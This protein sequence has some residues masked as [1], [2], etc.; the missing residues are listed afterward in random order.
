MKYKLNFVLLILVLS[1]CS[2]R[3][4]ANLSKT[5][6]QQTVEQLDSSDKS[7]ESEKK[8]ALPAEVNMKESGKQI[9]PSTLQKIIDVSRTYESPNEVSSRCFIDMEYLFLVQEEVNHFD[10]G[11]TPWYEYAL[12]GGSYDTYEKGLNC[13]N[14]VNQLY[15]KKQV[16]RD[17]EE[18][19]ERCG[20]GFLAQYYQRHITAFSP[21]G[22][23]VLLKTFI[24]PPYQNEILYEIYNN[25]K[26]QHSYIYSD[27]TFTDRINY[28][29]GIEFVS[30]DV[31]HGSLAPCGEIYPFYWMGKDVGFEYLNLKDEEQFE[32]SITTDSDDSIYYKKD[33]NKQ[34]DK[35]IGVYSIFD[36]KLVFQSDA[37]ED[38][39]VTVDI[40]DNKLIAGFTGEFHSDYLNYIEIDMKSNE[41][42]YLFT[43]KKGSFSPDGR[44]FACPART[45]EKRGYNIYSLASGEMTFIESYATETEPLN[46][47]GNNN[48]YCWVSK[49]KIEELRE[50]AKQ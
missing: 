26:Y 33:L 37:I 11:G 15:G 43:Y 32:I 8:S 2:N 16:G 48:V 49:N 29:K 45:K 47:L 28:S 7:L 13:Y 12:L 39:P 44:Y 27:I 4:Q 23:R 10:D 18:F 1:G 5:V 41:V 38:Y 46:Y 30:M 31:G 25:K 3:E 42:N 50:L 24:N 20:E 9:E 40:L 36:D 14:G 35:C 22:E 21:D 19:R 34:E 17:Y 6:V